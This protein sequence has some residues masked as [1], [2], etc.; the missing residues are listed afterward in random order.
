M[1]VVYNLINESKF[2]EAIKYSREVYNPTG[3]GKG[4]FINYTDKELLDIIKSIKKCKSLSKM[5]FDK[6]EINTIKNEYCL[7]Y[8]IPTFDIKKRLIEL[9]PN[10][11]ERLVK[12]PIIKNKDIP[13]VD[14]KN[15]LRGLN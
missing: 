9:I 2:T 3:K 7:Y 12:S 8:L 10:I 13:F 15:I 5:G 11:E 6:I 1:D 14:L 4:F